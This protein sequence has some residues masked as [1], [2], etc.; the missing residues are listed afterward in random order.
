MTPFDQIAERY[1]KYPGKRTFD[2]DLSDHIGNGYVISTRDFFVM[3]RAVSRKGT[4]EQIRNP[5]FVF[6]EAECDTWFVFVFAGARRDCL[7]FI[8]YPLKWIAWD[9]PRA[10]ALRFYGYDRMSKKYVQ[11]SRRKR[12]LKNQQR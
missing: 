6:P 1:E 3:G 7:R 5:A 9:Q 4:L 11:T 10:K 8:P 2:K 12:R